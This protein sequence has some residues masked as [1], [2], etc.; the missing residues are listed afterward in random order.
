[1]LKKTN[2]GICLHLYICK[3][4]FLTKSKEYLP[5]FLQE[6]IFYINQNFF[7]K[8]NKFWVNDELL[9]WLGLMKVFLE[10]SLSP[11]VLFS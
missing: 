4:Q 9:S 3:I 8:W 10:W 2:E 11:I 5:Y 7:S 6:H 1:M